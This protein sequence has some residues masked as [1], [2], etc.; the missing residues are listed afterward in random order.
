MPVSLTSDDLRL[1]DAA[2]RALL[3]PLDHAAAD[4][5]ADAVFEPLLPLLRP[6]NIVFLVGDAGG[7]PLARSVRVTVREV[8]TCVTRYG[9]TDLT[10][11]W[12]S[13]LGCRSAVSSD[14]WQAEADGRALYLRSETFN[15]FYRPLGTFAAGMLAVD[16]DRGP[17]GRALLHLSAGRWDH[18]LDSDRARALLGLLWPALDASV[19]TLE[20]L[21]AHR[22]ALLDALDATPALLVD[23]DGQCVHHTAALT[24]RLA[25]DPERA[26]VTEAA[27]RLA[28][29]SQRAVA[30]RP[31]ASVV[32]S[33]GRYLLRTTHFGAAGAHAWGRPL[34]AVL[35][36]REAHAAPS[37][38]AVRARFGLTA[39]QA[40]VALLLAERRTN[41]EVAAALS[42]SLA[43][44]RRHTE[45][46]LG[47]LG[48][49]SRLQ[50]GSALAGAAPPRA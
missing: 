48:V 20:R 50:V 26:R 28:A 44:A 42:I 46:V 49:G 37:V 33:A 36:E 4:A 39:Q 31:A 5:W 30:R 27:R 23:A 10:R 43:T 19:H 15:E 16:V 12:F 24:A 13:Q 6:D 45:A 22:A 18:P 14:L 38:E 47:T 21:G 25:A 41:A 29:S 40:R 32:T 2:Q 9:Q 1:L 34:V 35:V 8:E 7:R 11:R 3:S 17:F